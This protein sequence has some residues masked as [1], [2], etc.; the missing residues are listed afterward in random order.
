VAHARL[1][2]SR[3]TEPKFGARLKI[4]TSSGI[5]NRH[6]RFALARELIREKLERTLETLV[7]FP[8]ELATFRRKKQV[9]GDGT[10]DLTGATQDKKRAGR[11]RREGELVGL[12]SEGLL[13]GP[14]IT[15]G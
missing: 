11:C 9:F 10:R 3:L 15:L 7:T 13:P 4:K 5:Q 14:R 8:V 6:A 2:R 12:G 1:N